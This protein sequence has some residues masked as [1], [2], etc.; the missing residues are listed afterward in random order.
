MWHLLNRSSGLLPAIGRRT[1][2][3]KMLNM[4]NHLH[5]RC[6]SCVSLHSRILCWW[7]LIYQR[8]TGLT[9]LHQVSHVMRSSSVLLNNMGLQQYIFNTSHSDYVLDL[10][11]T[12]STRLISDVIVEWPF[13]NTDKVHFSVNIEHSDITNNADILYYN[14]TDAD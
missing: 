7:T 1:I 6:L 14:Y 8:L 12:D 13:G 10:V 2:P 3:S 9:T 11:L 5:L 4:S